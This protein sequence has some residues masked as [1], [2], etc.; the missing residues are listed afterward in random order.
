MEDCTVVPAIRSHNVLRLSY[1]KMNYFATLSMLLNHELGQ[2]AENGS[3][4]KL[5]FLFH[6]DFQILKYFLLHNR[7]CFRKKSVTY[8]KNIISKEKNNADFRGHEF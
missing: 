3:V 8:Y 7:K 1:T 2:W 4:I 6:V 5:D